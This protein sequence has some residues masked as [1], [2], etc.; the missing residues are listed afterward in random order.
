[1]TLLLYTHLYIISAT[2]A[3]SMTFVAPANSIGGRIKLIIQHNLIIQTIIIQFRS[4]T[5][6][7][8]T[9]GS[10]SCLVYALSGSS[11]LIA[12]P[13]TRANARWRDR[14]REWTGQSESESKLAL[15]K[16]SH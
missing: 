7:I 8:N 12:F 11:G 4:S 13:L 14:V 10:S 16:G 3:D 9:P 1:M 15:Q 2:K 5:N 6:A